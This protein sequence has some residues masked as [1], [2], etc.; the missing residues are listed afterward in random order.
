MMKKIIF[1]LAAAILANTKLSAEVD[2]AIEFEVDGI[3]YSITSEVDKTVEVIKKFPLYSGNV[4]IPDIVSYGDSDYTVT[5]IGS[6]AFYGST[7]LDSVFIPATVTLIKDNAFYDC[8]KLKAVSNLENAPITSIEEQAFGQCRSLYIIDFPASL[9]SIG[10]KAFKNCSG[11]FYVT[12]NSTACQDNIGEDAFSGVGSPG[13]VVYLTLPD[14]WEEEYLPESNVAAWHGGYFTSNRYMDLEP[15][16]QAALGAVAAAMEPYSDSSVLKSL[17]QDEIDN[18][19]S[20]KSR[21]AINSHKE[22]AIA[23]LQPFLPVYDEAHS[24][25][26]EKGK[27]EA[28][29]EMGEPCEDCPSVEITGQNDK[30]AII[31][32][33][34]KQVM[35][36]KTE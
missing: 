34:P 30:A 12:F 21:A 11:L 5:A 35:F 32:Y 22:A 9:T 10:D 4:D 6:G 29:G 14:G 13:S 36:R 15:Y 2:K 1:L 8:V 7:E 31:L 26:V 24:V 33:N 23:K 20:A 18:I 25:G 28:F 3:L 16:R 19:N 17:I 27:A